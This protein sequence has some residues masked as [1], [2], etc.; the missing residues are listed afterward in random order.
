MLPDR[1][2][3]FV[4]LSV[5]VFIESLPFVFLGI[6]LSIVVQVWLPPTLIERV[7]PRRPALRRAALSLLG[8]LLPVCECGNV[9]L[10]RGLILRGF[11]PAE[12]LTFLL[13]APILNPVTIITTYQAFGWD[14]G[15]LVAR[16]LGG[17]VIA[18]LVGW[19]FSRHPRQ[20]E[21]L[22]PQ[23]EASC[24]HAA[25]GG[26]HDHEHDHD[27]HLGED[28]EARANAG[29]LAGLSRRTRTRL[30]R[31]ALSFAEESSAMLPALAVGSGVAGAIQVGVPRETL[32]LLGSH[33]LL[34]VL[35][36]VAL[37]FIISICSNVDAFFI[38]SFGS[39]FMPGGI[40][41]FLVFGAMMDIK[42]LALLRTTFTTRTLLQLLAI[43]GLCSIAIGWGVNLVA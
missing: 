9:P 4:T 28:G 41:A 23:F 43:I 31:S 30:R 33:P 36:L 42:M 1:L 20:H 14:H 6:L 34:S 11:T 18:N 16:I 24:R 8:V 19:V 39:T 12:A 22:T 27:A 7:L 5:S 15:I 37:A 38:M 2:S 40:V 29:S 25:A 10:A 3:D 35:A 13:A 26:D 21:I 17:F 32:L